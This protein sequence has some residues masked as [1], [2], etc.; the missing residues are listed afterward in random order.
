MAINMMAFASLSQ[1]SP[2]TKSIYTEL[3]KTVEEGIASGKYSSL[4]GKQYKLQLEAL[5]KGSPNCEFILTQGAP[6]VPGEP[7]IA[8]LLTR[9]LIG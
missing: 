9:S 6:Q 7:F 1:L 8:R 2:D 4:Y 5:K 3:E